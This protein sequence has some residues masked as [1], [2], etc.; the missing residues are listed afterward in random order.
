ML[1]EEKIIY[2][3][4]YND[5]RY[6]K[7]ISE[8]E[9]LVYGKSIYYRLSFDSE[10]NNRILFIDFEGG[11]MINLE[12]NIKYFLEEV[13]KEIISIEREDNIDTMICFKLIT[14]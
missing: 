7:Q 6:L 8:N 14:K 12:D 9:Y 13:D 10:Q 2:V 1:L 3:S 5:N 4:R 11:P